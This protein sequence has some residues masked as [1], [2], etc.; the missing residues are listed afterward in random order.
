MG[1][2]ARVNDRGRRRYRSHRHRYRKEAGP[3]EI[4]ACRLSVDR[5]HRENDPVERN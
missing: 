3:D 4:G 2:D 5:L 1:R